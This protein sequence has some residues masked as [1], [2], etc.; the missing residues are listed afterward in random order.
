MLPWTPILQ[1]V[2]NLQ[3]LIFYNIY[4]RL[5]SYVYIHEEILIKYKQFL[6]K[7]IEKKTKKEKK[8]IIK[9]YKTLRKRII[10][11]IK[12]VIIMIET[13][14]I[15][16]FFSLN[17]YSDWIKISNALN[18][19]FLNQ[20]ISIWMTNLKN[21]SVELEQYLSKIK[22]KNMDNLPSNDVFKKILI[23]NCH[24]ASEFINYIFSVAHKSISTEEAS[25]MTVQFTC[26]SS[27]K[28]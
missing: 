24:K 6:K 18:K 21:S 3:N 15:Q 19:I 11:D 27:L 26:G 22:L 2:L 8:Q 17:G 16:Y 12:N 9:L 4:F 10:K 28:F 5:I 1:D 20:N 13:L 14:C 23:E 7:N 25:P